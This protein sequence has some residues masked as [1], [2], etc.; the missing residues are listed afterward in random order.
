MPIDAAYRIAA[1]RSYRL[2]F[3]LALSLWFTNAFSWPASFVAAIVVAMILAL[4][5]PAPPLKLTLVIYLK[6]LASLLVGLVVI[7]PL[8]M[9]PA[10]GVM[11][12]FLGL[13]LAFFF[14][15][16]GRVSGLTVML[17]IIGLAVVPSIGAN[18]VDAAVAMA[19]GMALALA[20]VPLFL[21]IAHAVFPEIPMPKQGAKTVE[22]APPEKKKPPSSVIAHFALRP[23]IV[24][25]PVF[26]FILSTPNGS[27]YIAMLIKAATLAAQANVAS[28]T[29]ACKEMILSTI[30]GGLIAVG[31]WELTRMWPS[32]AWYVLLHVIAALFVGRKMFKG[33]AL[34]PSASMWSY[35]LVTALIINGP[36]VFGSGFTGEPSAMRSWMRIAQFLFVSVYASGAVYIFDH[37]WQKKQRKQASQNT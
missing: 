23:V 17:A 35:A 13:Y 16:L 34:T 30:V 10:A 2:A 24:V 9:Y 27:D 20:I 19:G 31:I 28:T 3:G 7:W 21:W 32:L 36:A 37:F 33:P 12:I 1:Q 8:K 15:G 4:P 25:A 5:L 18:S 14:T 26:L 22:K 11:I 6:I 29:K